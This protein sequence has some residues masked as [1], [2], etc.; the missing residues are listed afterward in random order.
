MTN[1]EPKPSNVAIAAL[2]IDANHGA[3]QVPDALVDKHRRFKEPSQ[4]TLAQKHKIG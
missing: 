2:T 3:I 4:S 1:G